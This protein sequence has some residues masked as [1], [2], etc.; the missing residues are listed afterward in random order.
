MVQIL[1]FEVDERRYGLQLAAVERVVQAVDVTPLP[2]A[3]EVVWGVIDMHGK[4]VPVLNMRKRFG[5]PERPISLRDSFILARTLRRTVA[6][7]VDAVNSVIER[8]TADVIWPDEILP[9]LDQIQGVIQIED[10]MVLIHDLERFLS[11]DQE[12]E[13]TQPIT[14]QVHRES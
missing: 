10:G 2:H 7:V 9:H 13:L 12:V 6:L 1:S 14:H 3:P 11:L 4:I 8:A 5:L